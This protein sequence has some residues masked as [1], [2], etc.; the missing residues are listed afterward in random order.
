MQMN[1]DISGQ[2]MQEIRRSSTPAEVG[3]QLEK[4]NRLEEHKEV[5]AIGKY[6]LLGAAESVLK[7]LT[8]DDSQLA[9][10]LI[11]D[12]I[13]PA[14]VQQ[15]DTDDA[16]IYLQR[17]RETL[18]EWVGQY[19]ERESFRI[20]NEL[21]DQLKQM[22][23]SEETRGACWTISTFGFRRD[24]I[25]ISLWGVVGKE[26]G[27]PGDIA[28][29][30]ISNLRPSD[31]E[32]QKILHE[33]HRRMFSRFNTPLWGAIHRLA[34]PKSIDAIFR[35]WIEN[36]PEEDLDIRRYVAIDLLG[37][38]LDKNAEH[39]EL[40]DSTWE[41]TISLLNGGQILAGPAHV[42]SGNFIKS[43]NSPGAMRGSLSYLGE[44]LGT[45]PRNSHRRYLVY[46]TI[47]DCIRPRQ[48]E[49]MTGAHEEGII[50][51]IRAE[52]CL[53]TG[54]SG[55]SQTSETLQKESAWD[56]AL[57]LGMSEALAWY[58]A[59]VADEANPYVIQKINRLMAC[60]KSDPLPQ[61]V[62]EWVRNDYE[63]T[64]ENSGELFRR[65]SAIAIARTAASKEAL[66]ALLDFGLTYEGNVLLSSVDALAEVSFEL[67]KHGEDGIVESLIQAIACEKREKQRNVAAG[68]LVPLA[69][70]GLL[71]ENDVGRIQK[72]LEDPDLGVFAREYLVRT[73]G[74]VPQEM[75]LKDTWVLLRKMAESG[76]Q[77]EKRIA[78]YAMETFARHDCLFIEAE[79]LSNCLGLTKCGNTWDIDS[80]SRKIE[81][82]GY[83]V[84]WLYAFHQ[85]E[86]EPAVISI[87][88]E[89]YWH[90]PM[91]LLQFLADH[92]QSHP[93][94]RVSENI[95]RVAIRY[96]Y[97]QQKPFSSAL[98]VFG[99]LAVL[100]PDALAQE[101]WSDGWDQWLP[102]ARQSLAEALGIAQYE[103]KSHLQAVALL[104]LLVG[105]GLYR[106]RRSAYRSLSNLSGESLL[107]LAEEYSVSQSVHFRKRAAEAFSWLPESCQS[108]EV[109]RLRKRLVDDPELSVRIAMQR[110]LLER[111]NRQWAQAYL[112][113][114][115]E[116]KGENNNEILAAWRYGR[117][118]VQIADDSVR[119]QL[120]D[121]FE[122]S[123]LSPHVSHWIKTIIEDSEKQ[124]KETVRKWSEPWIA[125][126]GQ[127][128]S[129]KGILQLMGRRVPIDYSLW[130]VP[131]LS[132]SDLGMWGGI[133]FLIETVSSE[134]EEMTIKLEDGREVSILPTKFICDMGTA[135]QLLFTGMGSFPT[136]EN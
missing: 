20:R 32:R 114:I 70:K 106:V 103:A 86:F 89:G 128:E 68:A 109:E 47:Q 131:P 2:L 59:S 88:K 41:R 91:Q 135:S 132:P 78:A 28:L 45:S 113:Q 22:L 64:R 49:T 98:G 97:G 120:R 126:K 31:A 73:L 85:S 52:A 15:P 38:V 54:Y 36:S 9:L 12:Y 18:A 122:A 48:L 39:T 87:L 107:A 95:R 14:C 37:E 115:I 29:S 82:L 74:F 26:A 8:A 3:E 56:A 40:Q 77:K 34:D 129:G 136:K 123:S 25:L 119:E 58:E 90:T 102:E 51:A 61:V 44:Q 5:S 108:D 24:D 101:D 66:D 46:R 83:F 127:L 57:V 94:N 81:W 50:S 104:R 111:R 99:E 63:V 130:V 84:G 1:D 96:A 42:Y 11:Q 69:A 117:A 13:L 80:G 65:K 92:Y 72:L 30:V 116:V 76:D 27:E 35:Y 79:L 7:E 93:G 10:K 23:Y 124:W 19:A 121:Y 67:I 6:Q 110:S 71:T 105:D 53:N 4:I 62:V 55:L 33:L 133:A 75:I 43:C 134:I 60:F 21:L 100:M 125:Q 112:R 118:F 16:G 17:L